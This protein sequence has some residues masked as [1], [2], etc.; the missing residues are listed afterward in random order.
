MKAALIRK[1][2]QELIKKDQYPN[3]YINP[4]VGL[5]AD[6]EWLLVVNKPNPIYDPTTHKLV[7]LSGQ[8]TII[9]HE[10]YTHLNQY[11]IE[12][13]A[14]EMTPEEIES[15]NTPDPYAMMQEMHKDEGIQLFD[16]FFIK[17]ETE[18]ANNNIS[19]EEIDNLTELMYS[20][21][22]PLYRGVWRVVKT[23]LN[24]LQEPTDQTALGLFNW[25]KDSV[26]DYINI[27]Y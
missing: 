27:N 11:V 15:Y 16:E 23:K 3:L 10:E 8:I 13:V 21:I 6:L 5:D 4:V 26:T 1:S 18:R 2:T 7:Q 14:V 17:V 22:E 9:P 19:E 20:S 24:Q 12:S 25:M